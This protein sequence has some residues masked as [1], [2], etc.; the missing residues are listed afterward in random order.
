MTRKQFAVHQATHAVVEYR[1]TGEVRHD[2]DLDKPCQ[3]CGWDPS[4]SD[5]ENRAEV[6][7]RVDALIGMLPGAP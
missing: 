6:D 5:E 4:R 7:A 3:W 1:L 2:L